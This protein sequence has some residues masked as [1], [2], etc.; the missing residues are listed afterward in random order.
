M[1][2]K[3]TNC[4]PCS[5]HSHCS[6]ANNCA[7]PKPTPG[8]EPKPCILVDQVFDSCRIKET[9]KDA[10]LVPSDPRLR[11]SGDA[12]QPQPPFTFLGCSSSC[13]KVALSDLS[14]TPMEDDCNCNCNCN[15]GCHHTS[16]RVRV[17]G[18]VTVPIMVYYRD[19]CCNEFTADTCVT[20]PIDTIMTMP[21]DAQIPAGIEVMGSAVCCCGCFTDGH[22]VMTLDV[23]VLLFV[24]ARV[25]MYITGTPV[26]EVPECA[27]VAG[28][29]SCSCKGDCIDDFPIFAAPRCNGVL[30]QA[31]STQTNMLY[32]PTNNSCMRVER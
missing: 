7:C 23:V 9:I 27:K 28:G 32:A 14:V 12:C 4:S 10:V 24:T 15:C 16:G 21:C 3:P 18:N 26:D 6:G 31:S 11:A 22:F 29:N 1:N 2:C 30:L 25:P 8:C 19:A 13:S 17:R 20:L 5:C